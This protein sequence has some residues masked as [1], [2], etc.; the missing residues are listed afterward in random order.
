MSTTNSWGLCGKKK[1]FSA[2][3]LCNRGRKVF[4]F[5]SVNNHYPITQTPPIIEYL[6]NMAHVLLTLLS[7]SK[8]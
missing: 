1:T 3:W 2:Y 7:F 4:F 5:N 8:A 6:K